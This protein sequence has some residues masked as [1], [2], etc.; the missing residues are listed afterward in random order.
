MKICLYE[1]EDFPHVI[2]NLVRITYY[3]FDLRNE[4]EKLGKPFTYPLRAW[5]SGY[6]FVFFIR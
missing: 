2:N 5:K 4:L 3:Y 6:E 1:S